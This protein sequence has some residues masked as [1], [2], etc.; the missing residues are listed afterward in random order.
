[1]NK[2]KLHNIKENGFKVPEGYFDSLEGN[3]MSE[4]KLK[5]QV[6][7]SGFSTPHN[8]FEAL[9]DHILDQV[10]EEKDIKVIKLFSRKGIVYA[11]AIAAAVLLLFNLSIFGKSEEWVIDN[12]TVENY[13]LDENIDSYE[14]ASLLNEEDLLEDNFIEFNIEENTIENYI[15]DNLN[16][17]DL[18]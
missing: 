7:T 13:I 14:I 3:I 18:Y 10:S 6:N 4:L 2:N 8:Y 5:E 16:V 17:E 9:E 12:E 15:L 11:S 1:M